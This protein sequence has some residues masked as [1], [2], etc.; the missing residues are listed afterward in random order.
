MKKIY[1]YINGEL[2]GP[3]SGNY[4][5]NLSPV[6]GQVYSCVPDSDAQDVEEA[7]QA[8]K[9]AFPSW[10]GLSKQERYDYLIRLSKG[11]KNRFEELVVAESFDNGKPEWLARLVDIPRASTNIE[12]FATASLHYASELHDMDG[13]ALNYTLRKP[14]GVVGCISPWNLPIYLLTWKIAPA[15]AAGAIFQVNR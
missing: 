14:V 2:L 10:S 8:A 1:N 13:D 15:L 6:N 7:I 5:D 12:F 4:L 3:N 9:K 11:I